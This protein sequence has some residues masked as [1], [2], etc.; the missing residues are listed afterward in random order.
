[1]PR[2]ML[3]GVSRETD[4]KLHQ[5]E[6]LVRKWNPA[7]N[8][9]SK[10][11]IDFLWDRHIHDSAQIC[12][13]IRP[14]GRWV[15]LGSGGGFPGLI[16]AILA[17]GANEDLRLTLVESDQ[18]KAAF[19]RQVARELSLEV[20]V[21]THRIETCPPQ[22]ADVISAR[23]LAPL[24]TLLGFAS[25]H[26]AQSGTAIFPKGARWQQEVESARKDWHFDLQAHT[27]ATDPESALLVVKAISHA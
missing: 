15:D 24:T 16:I 10:A 13:H 27:S 4:E 19:L 6:A 22:S 3:P 11:S 2:T 9:V 20:S 18:R 21:L 17:Q 8:L 14:A 25:R 7:I 5:F 1:M 12:A 23:A 26:L